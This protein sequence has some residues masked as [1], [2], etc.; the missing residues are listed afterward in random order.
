VATAA[1]P[2]GLTS[3]SGAPQQA[4]GTWGLRDRP[5]VLWLVLAILVALAHPFVPDAVWLLTHLVLLGA[6]THSAMVWSTHFA[7]TILKSPPTL[8]DRRV[9]SRRLLLLLAGTTMVVVGVPSTWWPLSVTGAVTVST[10]VAWHAVQLVR[11]LRRALPGRFRVTVRFYVAAAACLPVGATFGVLLARQ[12]A[13]PWH[14]RLLAAHVATMA[15]GWLGLT[16]TGTLVTLWPTMLRTRMDDRAERLARQSLPVFLTALVVVDATALTGLS[17][18]TAAGLLLWL[19]AL[20]WWGRALVGP[21]RHRPPRELGPASVGL[22]L[23]WLAGGLVAAAATVATRGVADLGDLTGRIAA[24]V[25]AG[26]GLQLLTGALSHL[27]PS[28]LGG[29]PSVVRAGQRW[30]EKGAV[31]RLTLVNGGLVVCLLP[32]PSGVRVVASTLVLLAFAAFV[33]LMLRGIR[34]AVAARRALATGTPVET[35]ERTPWSLG[36]LAAATSALALVVAVAGVVAGPAASTDLAAGASPTGETTTVRVE[37]RDMA[38]HPSTIDVPAGNRL[39]VELVNTDDEDTHDLVLP[40][41]THTPRLAPGDTATLDAGVIGAST[42]GWCSVVGHRRMG[43]VLAIRVASDGASAAS[44]PTHEHLAHGSDHDAAAT[45]PAY[46]ATLP[47]TQG[48]VHR[49]DLTIDETVLEVAPGVW[50]RRWTFDGRAP[51]PVLHGQVG[52]RFVVT[53]HNAAE[54]THSIDFHAGERA[55]DR[56]MRAIPPGGTLVYRFTARRA[57]IWMYHCSTMPMS[58]HIA[59]GL[60]GAVVIDPPGLAPV[61]HEWVLV[62]SETFLGDDTSR[63]GADEV[64]DDAVAA[65]EPDH[66]AFNGRAFQYD[67]APLRAKAGETVRM[68]VLDAGPNRPMAFHVVGEQL[69]ATWTEGAWTLRPGTR[70]GAQVL[71]LLP[72]QGGFVELTFDEPGRYPFVNHVMVDA[73]RGEHGVVEVT[74]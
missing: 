2:R 68:W 59:A 51:G 27:V 20:V 63:E 49:V 16:M 26:F 73:E 37:A 14:G 74:R 67:T 62:G 36:Q 42:E 29:G 39:V 13:D 6:L 15:L 9:Q 52:D 31:A 30:L 71:P 64:D 48:R 70:G 10:A 8:D 17:A 24:V 57:G 23:V 7:A 65:E 43:M 56:V 61:D 55:P 54:M 32:V 38:F 53:V 40:D 46:D 18:G 22:A 25:A 19:A 60:A 34:A 28:V 47:R 35:P 72:A 3:P 12:P 44:E 69:D 5:G 58:S 4:R 41:G 50:Q 66:V 11:R 45:S 21:L 33:P 1:D